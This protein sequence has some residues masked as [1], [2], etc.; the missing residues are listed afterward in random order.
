[1]RRS[2]LQEGGSREG[3]GVDVGAIGEVPGVRARPGEGG[4]DG[5]TSPCGGKTEHGGLFRVG[6]WQAGLRCVS[7]AAWQRVTH[8]RAGS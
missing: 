5:G 4:R 3:W 2:T 7:G 8:R 1:M 6:S